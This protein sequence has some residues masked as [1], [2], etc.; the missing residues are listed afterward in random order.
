VPNITNY[1]F[2]PCIRND[3]DVRA[4]TKMPEKRREVRLAFTKPQRMTIVCVAL[5]GDSREALVTIATASS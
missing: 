4:R 1:E 3:F 2:E 5:A